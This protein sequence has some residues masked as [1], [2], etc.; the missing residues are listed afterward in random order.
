MNVKKNF[1][2]IYD[3]VHRSIVVPEEILAVVN[4][5][6]LQRLSWIRHLGLAYLVFPG[7]VHTRFEHSL[8]TYHVASSVASVLSLDEHDSLLLEYAAL[9]HDVGH[10]PLSHTLD[11]VFMH[12]YNLDH[13]NVGVSLIKGDRSISG[14]SSLPSIMEKYGVDP[15]EVVSV[16]TGANLNKKRFFLHEI[17]DGV[18]DID[19]VDYLMR[20]AYHTGVA[21]GSIDD[22][23]LINSYELF[24]GHLVVGKKG[25]NAAE[26]LTLARKL[27]YS[28]V[29]YHKTVRIA[30]VMIERAV[31]HALA[32][33]KEDVNLFDDMELFNWLY[34]SNELSA[35][36]TRMVRYRVLYKA[37]Y[38]SGNDVL[39]PDLVETLNGFVNDPDKRMDFE[40]SL[41]IE[42]TGKPYRIFFDIPGLEL[43]KTK[44]YRKT[45][46]VKIVKNGEIVLLNDVSPLSR[47]ISRKELVPY[48][49]MVMAPPQYVKEVQKKM[50]RIMQNGF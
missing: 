2:I 6:E 15:E 30:E 29:Y 25:I 44:K 7:G 27:M 49:F 23:R 12:F 20:D 13:V 46:G 17:I 22:Q 16:I 37:A 14:E 31:E 4:S 45:G 39:I 50:D 19:Q 47:Q 33:K 40:R 28:S 32:I 10:G 48:R 42:I 5:S 18:A 38:I 36:L 41:S 26:G 24:K 11:S 1:K 9:L 34:R 21:Y 43:D 8:G 35:E 3:N